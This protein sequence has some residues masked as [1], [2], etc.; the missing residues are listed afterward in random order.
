MLSVFVLN[1]PGAAGFAFIVIKFVFVSVS[2]CAIVSG[3]PLD[4][5][6]TVKLAT[7]P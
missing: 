4:T 7:L 5:N 3:V 6:A 1:A 2:D